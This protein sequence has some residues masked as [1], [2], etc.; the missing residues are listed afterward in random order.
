MTANIVMSQ[1][2]LRENGLGKRAC[3][4]HTKLPYLVL[5]PESGWRRKKTG[6]DPLTPQLDE[7]W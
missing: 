2:K 5:P 6:N 1:V 3:G 4:G 7:V